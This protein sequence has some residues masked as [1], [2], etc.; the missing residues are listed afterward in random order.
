MSKETVPI[1]GIWLRA[2]G[3][4]IQVLVEQNGSWKLLM[5]EPFHPP[6]DIIS[7][8]AEVEA[9]TSATVPGT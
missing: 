9:I 4:I 2:W 7:H 6:E 1:T 3:N 8:I 5:C